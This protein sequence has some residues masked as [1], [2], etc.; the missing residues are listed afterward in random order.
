MESSVYALLASYQNLG[1]NVARSLGVALIDYLG[2]KTTAPCNFKQLPTAIF[3]AHVLLPLLIVPMVFIL[4]PDALMTDDLLSDTHGTGSEFARVPSE[5]PLESEVSV[6]EKAHG[7]IARPPKTAAIDMELDSI[8]GTEDDSESQRLA[9]SE[10]F[11]V[12]S[13]TPTYGAGGSIP[14]SSDVSRREEQ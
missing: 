13:F 10:S 7:S 11:S 4:I 6:P 5:D 8:Y 14:P 1:S 2:I 3:I 9:F 12:P